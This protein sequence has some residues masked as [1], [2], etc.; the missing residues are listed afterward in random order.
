MKNNLTIDY[1]TILTNHGFNHEG[2]AM[3]MA[4]CHHESMGFTRTIENL[5]YSK[6]RLLVIFPKY[7]NENNINNYLDEPVKIASRVYANRMGNGDENSEDGYKYRGRGYLQVTGRDNYAK[8]GEYLKLN[9]INYPNLLCHQEHAFDSAIW[10]FK[11]NNLI[12]DIDIVTVS[13]KIN[14][15]LNGLKEREKLYLEYLK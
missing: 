1:K 5:S 6:E 13:K 8:C 11:H 10:F 4:Q 7:F 15:G 12:N 9:L 2:I 14:G 3:F